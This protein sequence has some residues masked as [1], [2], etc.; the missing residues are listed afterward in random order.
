MT[1]ER[2]N[3]DY[4]NLSHAFVLADRAHAGTMRKSGEA[5]ITHPVA[6]F[7]LLY[8]QMGIREINTLAASLV[9]DVTED[10]PVTP[11]QIATELGHEVAKLV[12]G[13][14]KIRSQNGQ[15]TDIETL[16]KLTGAS[17]L[18]PRVGIIKLADRLHNMT[19]LEHMPASSQIKK[20]KE[21]LNVYVPLAE[22]LGL[23]EIKTQL[24]DLAF[25]YLYP[26]EYKKIEALSQADPRANAV[27][28][29]SWCQ[30]L[31]NLL[32]NHQLEAEIEVRKLGLWALWQKLKKAQTSGNYKGIEGINDFISLRIILPKVASCYQ[33]QGLLEAKFTGL[34]D[35]DKYDN[36]I[37]SPR[38]NDYRAIHHTFLLPEGELEFAFITRE[39]EE[40]N[41]WGVATLLR[42][43]TVDTSALQAFSRTLVFTPKDEVRFFPPTATVAD[44][45]YSINPTL[46][47][48]ATHATATVY[49]PDGSTKDITLE[50]SDT[51]PN[52]ATIKIERGP[53]RAVPDAEKLGHLL[54]ETQRLIAQQRQKERLR[55]TMERGRVVMRHILE[56]RG[57]IEFTDLN[58]IWGVD[59]LGKNLEEK[60]TESFA[61]PS[62]DGLYLS[63]GTNTDK[64]RAIANFL[65]QN[66]VTKEKLKT[67]TILIEGKKVSDR[68]IIQSLSASIQEQMGSILTLQTINSSR[69]D[70]YE[71]R[72]VVVGL[73]GAR[74]KSLKKELKA[75]SRFNSVLMV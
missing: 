29:A 58:A 60:I 28:Q 68:G 11:E 2:K 63:L 40:F 42:K 70:A 19:T 9:H 22:S 53:N 24:E 38:A 30:E 12:D 34:I 8:N 51:L 6:V 23:W 74:E 65:D 46:G 48:S 18:D 10:T 73:D 57:F 36:F 69:S 45:A 25:Y 5:Y 1:S 33:C 44:F 61:V 49:S 52:S 17:F 31:K 15:S 37:L 13:V 3:A 41:Q 54:P 50:L 67:T 14:S 59:I 32:A 35:A 16:H 21:T 43:S 71:L 64:A 26:E 39:M 66:Q 75:S 72:V 47:A 55:E 20:I 56:P 7:N 27:F 62:M 4:A